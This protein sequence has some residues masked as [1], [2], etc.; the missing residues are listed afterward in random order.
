MDTLFVLV[1]IHTLGLEPGNLVEIED[2]ETVRALVR[3]GLFT[4]LAPEEVIETL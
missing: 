4:L 3:A 2:T 1:G